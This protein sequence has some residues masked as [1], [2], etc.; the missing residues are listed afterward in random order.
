MT[1][2]KNFA[3][4]R[5]LVAGT[6]QNKE[7]CRVARAEEKQINFRRKHHEESAV[8]EALGSMNQNDMRRFYAT[9]DGVRHNIIPRTLCEIK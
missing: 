7:R 8:A 3:R 6:R 2:V 4:S 5:I 1:E 9:V